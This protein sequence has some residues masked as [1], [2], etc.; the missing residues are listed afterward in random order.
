MFS[1]IHFPMADPT[2]LPPGP[3]TTIVFPG[4][5]SQ[6]A[7]MGRDF[8]DR[9]ATSRR[10][11]EEAAD[12][13]GFDVAGL[14]FDGDERLSL[15]EYSQPAILTTQIAM[16]CALAEGWGV[17]AERFGGH[18]LGEYTALVAAGVLPLADAVR[19]VRERGRL[20]QA[21]VPVGEGGMAA[22][23]GENLDREAI[24]ARAG[25]ID[26]DIANDN[27]NGQV[28][29]SGPAP[30]V[31]RAADDLVACPACG[32]ERVVELEVSAPFHSRMMQPIEAAFAAVLAQACARWDV[33]RAPA[34]TSNLT[35]AFHDADSAL[36]C[37]RLVGQLGATVRWRDN[38]NAILAANGRVLEVGPSRP[39]RGFFR[40]VGV[41][42]TSIVDVRSA[43][44]AFANVEP[45]WSAR[46]VAA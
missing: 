27:S 2:T 22:V 37:E 18:S 28:V 7:G 17:S 33:S 11:Y 40:S 21:A 35:G 42:V 5:G 45:A 30:A 24:Y 23:L 6:R 10:V 32:V 39:L 8:F 46:A 1:R 15:T 3:P 9:F 34:V 41:D 44:R 12:A 25:E 19:I 38:M 20:M 26:V 4:Q 31:R 43:G 13:A 36:L 29:L 16:V 14:C